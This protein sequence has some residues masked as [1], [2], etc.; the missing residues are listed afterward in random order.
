MRSQRPTATDAAESYFT[1]IDRVEDGDV[2]EQ[3][4]K[5]IV[6]TRALLSSRFLARPWHRLPLPQNLFALLRMVEHELL[7]NYQEV[8]NLD[9]LDAAVDRAIDCLMGRV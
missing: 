7:G 2:I 4:A 1:Y 3:L 8:P 6:E 9:M 5:Q